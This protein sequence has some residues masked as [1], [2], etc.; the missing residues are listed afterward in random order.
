M[1][2]SSS[3]IAYRIDY[4]FIRYVIAQED[5]MK[6]LTHSQIWLLACFISVAAVLATTWFLQGTVQTFAFII[7]SMVFA[8]FA[9]TM[10]VRQKS[11]NQ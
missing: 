8:F 11:K 7:I 5:Q 9:V 6:N 10:S 4:L 1:D 2:D 3:T